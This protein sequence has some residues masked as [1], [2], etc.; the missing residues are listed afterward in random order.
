M[1]SKLFNICFRLFLFAASGSIQAQES[2]NAGGGDATGNGGSVAYSVGQVFYQTNSGNSTTISE[3]V[4]QPIEISTLVIT[5]PVFNLQ[6]SAFPN[7]TTHSVTISISNIKQ[8][9][10]TY[11]LVDLHGRLL[12]TGSLPDAKNSIDLSQ[13]LPATYIIMVQDAQANV[14]QTFKLIKR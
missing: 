1:E 11:Q 12:Q 3:G 7:P 6:L 13:Y 5:S 2:V 10:L 9:D 4:Q 8:Q 14:L